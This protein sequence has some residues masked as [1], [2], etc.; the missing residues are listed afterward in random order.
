MRRCRRSSALLT[1]LAVG[2]AL[3]GQAA[4]A[5]TTA[6][7]ATSTTAPTVAADGLWQLEA[8]NWPE[9]SEV[10]GV[11]WILIDA[12]NGQILAEQGQHQLRPPASTT[13]LLTALAVVRRSAPD[14]IVTVSFAAAGEPGASAGLVTGQQIRLDDLLALLLLR[15]GNDAAI[16]LAEHTG[17]SLEGFS[18]LMRQEA[19]VL[20][21]EQLTIAEP[22][23]LLDR[24][25]LSARQLAVIGRA[26][27]SNDRLRPMVGA[28]IW[29]LSTGRQITNRNDLLGV[30]VGA[31]GLKT[32]MTTAAGW[33]LVASA[34]R[35]DRHLVA[36]VLG[37]N[38]NQG[39]F[40]AAAR[41]LEHGFAAFAASPELPD[42]QLRGDAQWL[43]LGHASTLRPLLPRGALPALVGAVPVEPVGPDVRWQWPS[44]SVGIGS[45]QQATNL[46][47]AG[48]TLGR[49][50][51]PEVVANASS[52]AAQNAANGTSR[53]GAW[54]AG[55]VQAAMRAA[56]AADL[57]DE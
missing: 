7:T 33:S 38:S 48:A 17:G 30:L 13:K 19:Q 28:A 8:V 52:S 26:V 9:P 14:E 41:L 45:W 3:L 4:S 11:S 6:T 34:R 40:T 37:A 56:S 43:E 25:R 47:W 49:S 55:R 18:D 1:A 36:V 44:A 2:M 46:R 53:L 5:T 10:D 39:R 50:P 16:A 51:T 35:G 21:L 32:G 23:G 29:K 42:L 15:S 31:T 54:L 12:G 22:H 24:N 20:G 27:L 57:W